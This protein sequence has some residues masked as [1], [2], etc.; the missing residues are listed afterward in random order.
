MN[1]RRKYV[2]NLNGNAGNRNL[3]DNTFEN[4]WNPETNF[5][6]VR[7]FLTVIKQLRPVAW[8]VLVGGRAANRRS[9]CI[10]F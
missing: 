1:D 6:L 2:A 10:S 5:L 9:F 7:N 4:D 8:A 3:N